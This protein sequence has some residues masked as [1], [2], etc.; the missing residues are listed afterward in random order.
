MKSFNLTPIK[1][2]PNDNTTIPT[3]LQ[4]SSQN[5]NKEEESLMKIRKLQ[6]LC[7]ELAEM[8]SLIWDVALDETS[9]EEILKVLNHEI[10]FWS[11]P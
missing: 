6:K 8:I 3:I 10:S 9:I 5:W 1:V 2:T 11:F 4:I 7:W